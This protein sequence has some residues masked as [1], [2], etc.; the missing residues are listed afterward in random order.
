[1]SHQPSIAS[2]QKRKDFLKK[3]EG[4]GESPTNFDV[5]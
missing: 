5:V 2:S 4:H 1:M 3:S